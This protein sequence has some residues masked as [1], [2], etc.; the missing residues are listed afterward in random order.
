MDKLTSQSIY[1]NSRY[2]GL[3]YMRT[4]SEV[5]DDESL[6]KFEGRDFVRSPF[7]PLPEYLQYS[8]IIARL[9]KYREA[10]L[11]IVCM[12]NEQLLACASSIKQRG[13]LF[14]TRSEYDYEV[15]DDWILRVQKNLNPK[16][17]WWA[18]NAT[19][20]DIRV[21]SLPFGLHDCHSW[22]DP[23]DVAGDMRIIA[24]HRKYEPK[25]ELGIIACFNVENFRA[26]R[27]LAANCLNR[28][29]ETIWIPAGSAEYSNI[30]NLRDYYDALSRARFVANPRGNGIDTN[31]FYEAIYLGAI[32]IM[33]AC[34][35]LDCHKELP[36]L[37][38]E[39][40]D[41]LVGLD[42]DREE[43]RIRESTWNLGKMLTSYWVREIDLS[44][45]SL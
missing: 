9:S 20:K 35:V 36:V 31:R 28:R 43:Q 8:N 30:S 44:Y 42:L 16:F 6:F 45:D 34:N 5:I 21:R 32:P 2:R 15:N 38:I 14:V 37:I 29:Q 17:V 10:G 19:A 27:T 22:G 11:D 7:I 33:L 3:D 26:E 41:D 40:W 23:H 39:S 24:A 4:R 25:R 1:P 13:R 12:T 18:T